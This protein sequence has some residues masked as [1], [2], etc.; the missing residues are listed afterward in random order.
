MM[1]DTLE[2]GRGQ[3]PLAT[4]QLEEKGLQTLCVSLTVLLNVTNQNEGL[5][6]TAQE[7]TGSAWK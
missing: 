1:C 7:F 6:R 4:A 3:G 5:Q 2:V